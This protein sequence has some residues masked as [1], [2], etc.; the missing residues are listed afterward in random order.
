MF[1]IQKQ[2]DGILWSKYKK[3]KL[4]GVYGICIGVAE[5]EVDLFLL[6]RCR[7]TYDINN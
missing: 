2:M 1:D 4:D 3:R 5:I 6:L 7:T